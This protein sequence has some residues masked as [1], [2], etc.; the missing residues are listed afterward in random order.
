MM[1]NTPVV[2]S[3][4]LTS[5][6]LAAGALPAVAQPAMEARHGAPVATT[7]LET[8]PS[9]TSSLRRIVHGLKTPLPSS[10]GAGLRVDL[11]LE[12]FGVAPVPQWLDEADLVFG[13][14]TYGAP[15]H[16]DVLTAM[17][18][19]PLRSTAPYRRL[20]PAWVLER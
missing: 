17:T 18:P 15:T 3:L 1:F 7:P 5:V 8:S 4:L 16:D 19:S 6:V 14:P 2:S 20:R 9:R 12:V 10:P 11:E 13:A